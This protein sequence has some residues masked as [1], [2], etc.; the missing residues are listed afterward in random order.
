MKVAVTAVGSQPKTRPH[1]TIGLT[2]VFWEFTHRGRIQVRW[3]NLLRRNKM[4]KPRYQKIPAE[5][6]N[7]NC[8]D[9]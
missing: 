4:I 8:L 5:R 2:Q 9:S 1:Q 7:S 3:V 6:M